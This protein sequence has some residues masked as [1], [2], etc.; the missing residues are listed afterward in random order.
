MA[1]NQVLYYLQERAIEHAVAP[2]CK[3]NGVSV[4]AYSPFGSGDFPAPS[5]PGGAVLQQVADRLGASARQL[6]LQFLL[7]GSATFVIPK[8]PNADHASENARAA[9]LI[10]PEADLEAIGRAFPLGRVPSHLPML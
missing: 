3:V 1:C 10:L 2:W 5:S 9:E 4:V 7:R 8:A 6:A